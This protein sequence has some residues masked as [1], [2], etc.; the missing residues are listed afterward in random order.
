M[1]PPSYFTKKSS[2]EVNASS[3]T[4]LTVTKSKMP[5]YSSP[6]NR[7][8]LNSGTKSKEKSTSSAVKETKNSELK[9][10]FKNS[11]IKLCKEELSR[12][13][14]HLSPH[15][16]E[17]DSVLIRKYRT[18]LAKDSC[19]TFGTPFRTNQPISSTPSKVSSVKNQVNPGSRASAIGIP[20]I[21]TNQTLQA[22]SSNLDSTQ[23]TPNVPTP[24]SLAFLRSTIRPYYCGG[25]CKNGHRKYNSRPKNYQLNETYSIRINNFK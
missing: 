10:S 13:K 15:A 11:N 6:S 19:P 14:I 12:K 3:K 5:L 17:S 16:K 18:P 22:R 24:I 2:T 4:N 21:R 1:K 9:N 7:S 8:L 25:N 20:F 23:S